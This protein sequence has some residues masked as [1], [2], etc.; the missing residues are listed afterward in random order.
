[1]ADAATDFRLKVL[2][3]SSSKVSAA[4]RP[5]L[6]LI[7]ACHYD[8]Q[9]LIKL[10]DASVALIDE[11]ATRHHTD[12]VIEHASVTLTEACRL[13]Q[14]HH[15]DLEDSVS[16][17]RM[18]RLG[19]MSASHEFSKHTTILSQQRSSVAI[20]I[21]LLSQLVADKAACTEHVETFDNLDIPNKMMIPVPAQTAEA[22]K[23]ST[24]SWDNFDLLSDL[25]DSSSPPTSRPATVKSQHIVVP[26]AAAE[27]EV[28]S[29]ACWDN[30][31]LLV[32]LLD[33]NNPPTSR[34]AMV[35]T[36]HI[37]HPNNERQDCSSPTPSFAETLPPPYSPPRPTFANLRM[38]TDPD[39]DG[40]T[41]LLDDSKEP[42]GFHS[43]V[44]TLPLKL[45]SKSPIPSP[46][47]F[48]AVTVPPIPELAVPPVP[49]LAVPPVPE[50]AVPPVPELDGSNPI[51]I[52]PRSASYHRSRVSSEPDFSVFDK[53]LARNSKLAEYELTLA[54]PS[55][56]LSSAPSATP[57]VPPSAHS[58]ATLEPLPSP[59]PTQPPQQRHPAHN[60]SD[61]RLLS[62]ISQ[63][64][65]YRYEGYKSP[66]PQSPA[67]LRTPSIYG[68]AT[69]SSLLEQVDVSVPSS[70][71]TSNHMMNRLETNT[72]ASPSTDSPIFQ[73]HGLIPYF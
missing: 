10:R 52:R 45:L 50:L 40:I 70:N 25:L 72:T 12:L 49:E 53:P 30:F 37:T 64:L 73:T 51:L 42:I 59:Q 66:P 5:C 32:D 17:L 27:P 56:R 35:P 48:S 21:R 57:S 24:S 62:T 15:F 20:E 55:T 61:G 7:R 13:F 16:K 65:I 71:P 18:M 14:R 63:E 36:Q 9:D 41:L 4:A 11:P 6:E 19:S 22:E 3:I 47:K 38:N 46:S 69:G 54:S 31:D 2:G 60:P 58:S 34:P 68:Q 1:M 26:R 29:S 43:I 67:S 33:G 39:D 8:V 28:P 44:P 23:R